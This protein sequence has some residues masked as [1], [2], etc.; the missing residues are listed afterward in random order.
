MASAY[1]APDDSRLVVVAI[2][3]GA[4]PEHITLDVV[5]LPGARAIE[6]IDIYVTD[7]EH[8]LARTESVEPRKSFTLPARSTTTF[9]VH[10]MAESKNQQTP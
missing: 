9:L 8:D 2:N 3:A 5:G 4:K 1:K 6:A 10:L 7:A